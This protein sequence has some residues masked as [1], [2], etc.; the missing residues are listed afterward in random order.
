L[1]DEGGE[2]SAEV[3]DIY[4]IALGN[5]KTE[6]P[7]FAG[8]SLLGVLQEFTD[9]K[10]IST[11]SEE[12]TIESISD[13]REIIKTRHYRPS[14]L[15]DLEVVMSDPKVE[16]RIKELKD[17]NTGEY[18]ARK[19]VEEEHGKKV[20]KI[21]DEKEELEKQINS[22]KGDLAKS[23]V[24]DLFETE[25]KSRKF[26][27]KEVAFIEKRIKDFT[28]EDPEMIEK[29][30]SKFLDK[31]VDEFNDLAEEFGQKKKDPDP[32]EGD[33]DGNGNDDGDGGSDEDPLKDNIFMPDD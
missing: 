24:G 22:M 5:S 30:F 23:R 12:M 26:D 31:K 19:R 25:K 2:F 11:R 14:E 17:V 10:N 29:E 27:E 32:G 15:F 20:K 21:E 9:N 13:L 18:N 4:G 7:G 33:G 16:D 3:E 8:A 1:N 6:K 28:P